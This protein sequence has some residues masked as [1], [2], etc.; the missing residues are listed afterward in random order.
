LSF[1]NSFKKLRKNG[2][3]IIEDVN[4]NYLELSKCT[5]LDGLLDL[6]EEK[7]LSKNCVFTLSSV[8]PKVIIKES[9]P[10]KYIDFTN[11][12]IDPATKQKVVESTFYNLQLYNSKHSISYC[13]EGC[14][15]V[16]AF[17]AQ[18]NT[19]SYYKS[20]NNG[21]IYERDYSSPI[22]NVEK[23]T[24]TK[25][26]NNKEIDITNVTIGPDGIFTENNTKKN[27]ILNLL[28]NSTKPL[29]LEQP[30]Q[31][32]KSDVIPPVKIN[33][34]KKDDTFKL[35]NYIKFKIEDNKTMQVTPY[36]ISK[37]PA[38]QIY[39][40]TNKYNVL[41]EENNFKKIIQVPLYEDPNNID[42]IQKPYYDTPTYI[43]NNLVY[44]KTLI[45]GLNTSYTP[46]EIAYFE[47]TSSMFADETHAFKNSAYLFYSLQFF[48]EPIMNSEIQKLPNL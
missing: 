8:P 25:E 2:I 37:N 33:K 5:S 21:Y 28:N 14:E 11:T 30:K 10:F 34:Y 18:D 42:K 6:C 46:E 32:V 39:F 13:A 15:K 47:N 44:E 3:Y 23:F 24:E 26:T 27:N 29:E 16:D 19:R 36:F 48:I 4:N 20:N 38:E 7:E 22:T 12:Y 40:F 35:K 41:N 17:C 31:E 43:N 45:T 1:F 9:T